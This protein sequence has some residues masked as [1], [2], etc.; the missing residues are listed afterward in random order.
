M[1]PKK[2]SPDGVNL[3]RRT[4]LKSTGFVGIATAAGAPAE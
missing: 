2:D 1:A 4:F 3:S